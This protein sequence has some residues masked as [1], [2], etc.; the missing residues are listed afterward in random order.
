[1][2]GCCVARLLAGIPGVTVTLVDIDPARAQTAAALGVGFAR[3]DE[4]QGTYEN[5]IHTSATAAGLQRCLELL[6]P[7]GEVIELSWYGSDPVPL[8]LGGSFH[9]R[10][11]AIRASQVGAVAPA[12]RSTRSTR[13]RLMLA[14]ELLRDPAFDELLEPAVPFA[15]LPA[16]MPGLLRGGGL[17]QLVSYDGETDWETD[18]ER[19]PEG[20]RRCSV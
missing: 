1:M 5:V 6:G 20:E 11:L 7:D 13:D 14:L 3:P 4:V 19:Q 18:W 17:L 2:V 9:S 8:T 12:R 15:D 10:R 16:L